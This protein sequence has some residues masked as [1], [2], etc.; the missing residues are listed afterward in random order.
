MLR[1]RRRAPK[2]ARMPKDLEPIE[3]A[4]RKTDRAHDVLRG[5]RRSLRGFF[6]PKNVAVIGASETERTVGRTLLWNLVSS[7]FGGTVYPVNP[8]RASVLGIRAYP[9]IAEVPDK[10]DLAVIATPATTVPGV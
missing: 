10:I 8:K 4:E 5:A 1:C 9:N 2:M 7:P 3:R 6:H